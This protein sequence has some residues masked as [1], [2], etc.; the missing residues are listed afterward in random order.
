MK[1]KMKYLDHLQY[2]SAILTVVMLC[3]QG[4]ATLYGA[5]DNVL[6]NHHTES[7][8]IVD[9]ITND[10]LNNMT[11]SELRELNLEVKQELKQKLSQPQ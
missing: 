2:L 3:I 9:H 10:Q 5:F 7:Q 4:S 11:V 1:M 6:E 8:P